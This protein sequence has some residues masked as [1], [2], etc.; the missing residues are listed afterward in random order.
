VTAARAWHGRTRGLEARTR[1]AREVRSRAFR[2]GHVEGD[3]RGGRVITPA[4]CR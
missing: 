2:Q 4:G 1:G 3:Q